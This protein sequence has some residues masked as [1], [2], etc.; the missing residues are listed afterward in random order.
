V[1]F[2]GSTAGY[3]LFDHEGNEEILEEFK[4]EAVDEKLGRQLRLA[5]TCNNNEQVVAKRNDEL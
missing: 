4:V 5:A 1:K 3:V 2:F